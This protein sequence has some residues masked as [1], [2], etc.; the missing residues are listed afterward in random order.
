VWFCFASMMDMALRKTTMTSRS[1]DPR[2]CEVQ[3]HG[4]DHGRPYHQACRYCDIFAKTMASSYI[5]R[6]RI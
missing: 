1:G 6:L 2:R 4:H 5:V 3:A